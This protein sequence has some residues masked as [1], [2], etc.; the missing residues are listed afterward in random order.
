MA[1]S[2]F[3]GKN[4]LYIF[5]G[6]CVNCCDVLYKCLLKINLFPFNQF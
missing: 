2:L 3:I 6:C 5:G 4:K 1:L